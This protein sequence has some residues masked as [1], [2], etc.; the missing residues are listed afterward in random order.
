MAESRHGGFLGRVD[1]PRGPGGFLG[2]PE[3]VREFWKRRREAAGTVLK[4]PPLALGVG[5][6]LV[7]LSMKELVHR[8]FAA[9]FFS[10]PP[11]LQDPG[12]LKYIK[13][14]HRKASGQ[15]AA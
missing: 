3:A 10:W 15:K 6:G 12:D 1:D 9:D 11:K 4:A 2:H 5:V 14:W 8:L 13:D 7:G